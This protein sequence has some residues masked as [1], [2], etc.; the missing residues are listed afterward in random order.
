MKMYRVRE[1]F[2]TLQGEGPFAGTSSVFVR[3]VGCNLWNGRESGRE[4]GR[5][6]CAKWCDSVFHDTGGE[7]GGRYTAAELTR[8]VLELSNGLP[9]KPSVTLTG[10]EPML[11]LDSDLL[12]ELNAEGFA[13]DV[14]T[15]GTVKSDLY[16]SGLFRCVVVSPKVGLPLVVPP[17]HVSALKLVLSPENRGLIGHYEEWS[18]GRPMQLYLQAMDDGERKSAEF[19][20]SVMVMHNPR[21]RLSLQTH[22]FLELK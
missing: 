14:E 15:N 4:S 18:A 20:A 7:N 6:G 12:M 1:M 21:W 9:C 8:K 16:G 17:E 19:D 22:K 11:Q 10:G 3:M 5:G 13:C 2:L